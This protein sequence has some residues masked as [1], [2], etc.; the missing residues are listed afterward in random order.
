[1][2]KL[3]IRYQN[4]VMTSVVALVLV[5]ATILLFTVHRTFDQLAEESAA[6]NFTL[7]GQEADTKLET[8]VLQS[9]RFVTAQSR[10]GLD[11][12][13]MGDR[14]NAQDMVQPF[15]GSLEA[16][17]TLYSHYFGL[18]N[19]E[20]LQVIAIREDLRIMAALKAPEGSY[21]TVRRIENP[22]GGERS[23]RWEFLDRDRKP[24]GSRNQ[25]TEFRPSSR[26]W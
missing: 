5:V 23:E 1:M 2:E 26:P 13:V 12:F 11:H 8:L 20:F 10:V 17:P 24:I 19:D 16:D 6:S 9:G 7:I 4:W 14:I 18:A 15:L 3:N 21:F 25:A 22:L